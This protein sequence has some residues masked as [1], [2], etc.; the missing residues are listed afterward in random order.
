MVDFFER[1]TGA[2]RQRHMDRGIHGNT[3]GPA[4]AAIGG[5]PYSGRDLGK[6]LLDKLRPQEMKLRCSAWASWRV[7]DLYKFIRHAD[8]R[9]RHFSARGWPR[10]A[11]CDRSDAPARRRLVNGAHWSVA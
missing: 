8:R 10:R 2:I 9:R 7:P 1:Q 4:P 3:P 11:T 5:K 6:A